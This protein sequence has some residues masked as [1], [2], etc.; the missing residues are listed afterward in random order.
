MAQPR[1]QLEPMRLLRD[2]RGSV[3]TEY[4][5][6]LSAVGIV[7]AVAVAAWGGPLVQSFSRTRTILVAPAP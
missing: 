4:A 5:A 3:T 2:R 7:V 1:P 6:L